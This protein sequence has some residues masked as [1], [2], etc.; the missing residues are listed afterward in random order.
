[1]KRG[2][3]GLN[4]FQNLCL[5]NLLCYQ[6]FHLFKINWWLYNF[7]AIYVTLMYGCF[8]LPDKRSNKLIFFVKFSDQ[9]FFTNTVEFVM[10][11]DKSLWSKKNRRFIFQHIITSITQLCIKLNYLKELKKALKIFCWAVASFYSH[12]LICKLWDFTAKNWF[13]N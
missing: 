6:I 8:S 2:H 11:S 5:V 4:V 13:V 3:L 1:M 7:I 10:S 12:E 9:F